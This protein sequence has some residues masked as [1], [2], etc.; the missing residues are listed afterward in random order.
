[1]WG[2]FIMPVAE[3]S[4]AIASL[5]ATLNIAKAMIGLRDEE[6]FRAKSIEMQQTIMSALDNGIAAREA[7]TKQLDRVGTLEAEVA[8][9]K[10]WDAEKQ[11]Y[12]LKPNYSGAV[13]YMLKPN[14]RGA[15]PPHWLC[16]NCFAKGKKSF[17]LPTER[18]SALTRIYKCG[19]CKAESNMNGKPKWDDPAQNTS[20][21]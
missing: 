5:N 19:D 6:A 3:I 8:D 16:P 20:G 7:Y 1:L 14:A 15:E 12:E 13:A 21:G 18:G 10:A 17:L 9:L 4:A 2:G 11:K